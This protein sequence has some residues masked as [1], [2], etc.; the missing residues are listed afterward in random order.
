MLLSKRWK[1]WLLGTIMAV[2]SF[3][4]MCET[5]DADGRR[6]RTVVNRGNVGNRGAIVTRNGFRYGGAYRPIVVPNAYYFYG[7]NPYWGGFYP[8]Y[9][10]FPYYGGVYR[11]SVPGVGIGVGGWPNGPS[12]GGVGSFP[13]GPSFGGGGSFRIGR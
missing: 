6:G 2:G 5:A 13:S 10:Y 4:A 8:S 1:V 7:Y 11:R 9:N 3:A 12:F